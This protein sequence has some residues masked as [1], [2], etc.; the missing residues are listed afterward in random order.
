VTSNLECLGLAVTRDQFAALVKTATHTGFR[1]GTTG[2]VNVIDWRDPSGARLVL[3][4]RGRELA[5]FIPAF[6]G[7]P[8]ARIGN[9]QQLR[10]ETYLVDVLDA[11]GETCTRAA[12]DL[13][14]FRLIKPG[15]GGP[16]AI[17]AL[18]V[19]VTVHTDEAEFAAS[20]ASRLGNGPSGPRPGHI[21]AGHPWPPR[22][23]PES[24]IGYGAFAA[25]GGNDGATPHARLHG[26]VLHATLRTNEYTKATY[27]VARVRTVGMEVDLCFPGPAPVPGNI[28]GGT[29]YLV[30]SLATAADPANGRA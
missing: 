22:M 28:I 25:D 11:A 9:L 26:T 16:A 21:P 15:A 10:D 18:G 23:S 20:D 12:V 5:D 29:V 2:D 6:S 24:F 4:W 27:A 30:A 13:A 14:E 7:L 8:G 17:T 1:V 19:D 3:G